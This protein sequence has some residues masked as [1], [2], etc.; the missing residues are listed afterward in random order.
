LGPRTDDILR[1]CVLTLARN[2]RLALAEIPIC[3]TNAKWR[4]KLT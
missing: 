2:P 1:A 4:A 3:L